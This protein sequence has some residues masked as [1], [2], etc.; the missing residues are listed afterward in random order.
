MNSAKN[1]LIDLHY[2]PS[3]EY[4]TC[5][6]GYQNIFVD[7]SGFYKKQTFHNRCYILDSKKINALIVPIYGSK[8][9]LL[10]KDAKIYDAHRSLRHQWHSICTAYGRSPYFS[11]LKDEFAPFFNGNYKFLLDLNFGLLQTCFSLLGLKQNLQIYDGGDGI[12]GDCA[13]FINFISPK[14]NYKL[15]KIYKPSVYKQVFGAEFIPNLSI[16]DLLFC[17][18]NA[19]Y[20]ILIDSRKENFS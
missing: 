17:Q 20:S 3:L 6:L 4:F 13:N 5:L 2:L 15:N 19:A 1:L 16:L 9:L 14:K 7:F 11:F 8:R 10:Y 12:G 18:G